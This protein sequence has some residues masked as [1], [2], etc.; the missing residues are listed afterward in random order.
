MK[1]RTGRARVARIRTLPFTEAEV[2]RI[3]KAT[4]VCGWSTGE[5][6]IFERNLLLRLVALLSR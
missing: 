5:S 2:L 4:K 3:K 1:K 6:A